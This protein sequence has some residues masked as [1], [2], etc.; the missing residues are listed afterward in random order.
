M[1]NYIYIY[2]MRTGGKCPGGSGGAGQ[3]QEGGTSRCVWRAFA[4]S[5]SL[6]LPLSLSSSLFPYLALSLPPSLPLP[7]PPSLVL[8]CVWRALL[9]LSIYLNICFSIHLCRLWVC[10]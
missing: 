1:N 7:P 4:R 2:N 3:T 10:V 9:S 5:L 8:V 6:S